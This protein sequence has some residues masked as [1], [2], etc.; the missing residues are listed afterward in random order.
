MSRNS[1]SFETKSIILFLVYLPFCAR[2]MN[3]L[4][5][6]RLDFWL[7]YLRL[8][9]N[10]LPCM[11]HFYLRCISVETKA[12]VKISNR[13]RHATYEYVS[14]TL[15]A[16]IDFNRTLLKL[17]GCSRK[18]HSP[19]LRCFWLFDFSVFCFSLPNFFL[20]SLFQFLYFYILQLYKNT[21]ITWLRT[22]SFICS[23]ANN[24]F[25]FGNE[26]VGS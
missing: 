5:E 6:D 12:R 7:R 2:I 26:I 24:K 14:H 20:R 25:P 22:N 19:L 1:F 8:S 17:I 15:D 3:S 21:F 9:S 11:F 10:S 23:V 13:L 18:V 16:W 4:Y